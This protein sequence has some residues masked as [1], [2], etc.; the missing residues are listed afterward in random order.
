MFIYLQGYVLSCESI[1]R[2]KTEKER[3]TNKFFFTNSS[4]NLYRNKR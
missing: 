3:M 4:N 2:N 1:N